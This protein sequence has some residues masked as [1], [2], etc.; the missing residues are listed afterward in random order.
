MI[1]EVE[2]CLA[3]FT[4]TTV[5][6][7]RAAIMSSLPG[8]Q[9]LMKEHVLTLAQLIACSRHY[10]YIYTHVRKISQAY[11]KLAAA[12]RSHLFPLLRFAGFAKNAISAPHGCLLLF[13]SHLTQS[14][15]PSFAPHDEYM[16][17]LYLF[18]RWSSSVRRRFHKTSRVFTMIIE[19]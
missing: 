2:C 1:W 15:P 6:N 7:T 3:V 10:I 5:I 17:I 8:T 14:P 9:G 16:P 11:R 19:K 4:V 12:S 18:M 13:V